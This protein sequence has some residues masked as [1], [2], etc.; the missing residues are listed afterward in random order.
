MTH[1]GTDLRPADVCR[2]LEAGAKNGVRELNFAGL[3]VVFGQPVEP[4]PLDPVPPASAPIPSDMTESQH[5]QL[6]KESL[7][8]DE[9]ATR[10]DQ[11]NHMLIT[12][13]L[14]Y[15]EMLRHGDL[16]DESASNDGDGGDDED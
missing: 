14:R 9:F 8:Q 6:A 1:T 11:L 3:H 2:I 5:Q 10:E 7:A 12:D 4:V 13:P 15:E 16:T